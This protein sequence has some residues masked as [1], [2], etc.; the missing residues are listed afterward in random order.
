MKKIISI[1]ALV[2]IVAT[3]CC[4]FVAC[5]DK[6]GG[7]K[8]D[9]ITLNIWGAENDQAMLKQMCKAYQEAN[10]DKNFKF[11]FG[12]Q[13]ENDAADKVLNDPDSGPDIY[14]FASDQINKLLQGGALARIGGAI[15]TNI[16]EVNSP[17]SVDAATVT[18][19]GEDQLFAYPVTGD[20][21]YFLY[22]DKRV[23]SDQDIQT[24]DGIMA[25]A[26]E[27]QKEVHFK[28]NDDGW[29]LS[30]FFF[31]D[32]SLK[33]EVT[34]D[35][36][37]Q[38]KA[39]SI[40][41]NQP[42]GLN[43]LKS[44]INY[45]TNNKDRLIVTTD[46]GKMVS[47][48][49]EN[50]ACAVVSGT[51]NAASIKSVW[52]DNMGVAKLPTVTINGEQKQLVSYFGYKLMGVSGFSKNKGEAHKL[53][54]W[55]TNEQNQIS[56]YLTRGFAPTNINAANLDQVKNDEVLKAVFAQQEFARTQKG[57][58]STYWTPMKS[59]ITPMLTMNP[60][61]LTDDYLQGLLD[62]L[63]KQIAKKEA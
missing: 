26:T 24:L 47:A 34:Y 25:K 3:V 33:Y 32:D 42:A 18:I 35:E 7:K 9:Q 54:Q 31:A 1:I 36:N 28:L 46:D 21:T 10:P 53:A 8:G 16:K 19:G 56:R 11:L 61:D 38:E 60:A 52:G 14:S 44:V 43:A 45:V 13:G 40:N 58:P 4:V 39:I 23:L 2:L 59:L 62:A 6:G 12:V 5:G 55:L 22:Y 15:E 48:I 50:K 51:W 30:S 63:V 49:T 27:A 37:M 29:Y 17:D 20:N 57:V 41:Y